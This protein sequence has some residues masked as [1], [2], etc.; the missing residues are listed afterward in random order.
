MRPTDFVESYLDAW[1]HR[2]PVAVAR[3]FATTGIYC[4]VP[5]NVRQTRSELIVSLETLFSEQRQCYELIGDILA[6]DNTIAYQY[7]MYDVDESGQRLPGEPTRGAEFITMEGD[8]AVMITDY[9]D[10]PGANRPAGLVAATGRRGA[11]PKYAKS[12]LT[13]SQL[14][15]YKRKLER[16]MTVDRIYLQSDLTLP[17]LAETVGCTVNHLSQVINAGFDMSFF[18]YV[19]RHRIDHAKRLLTG[20]D[21]CRDAIL[22]IAFSVGFNSNSAFYSAFRKCVGMTPAQFRRMQYGK[23]R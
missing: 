19:N 14:N 7:R 10:V 18:D 9:Y 3:H 4:D 23:R 2:D 13:S 16:L 22:N 15:H 21:R 6:S 17:R 12:G 1:N 8:T 20:R 5:E 11:G